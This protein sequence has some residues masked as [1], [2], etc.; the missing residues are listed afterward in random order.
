MPVWGVAIGAAA[1]CFPAGGSRSVPVADMMAISKPSLDHS[2]PASPSGFCG[3]AIPR[4]QRHRRGLAEVRSRR[5]SRRRRTLRRS[6]A[7]TSSSLAA[8]SK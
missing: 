3:C 7:A 5:G 1:T 8:A 4:V 2:Q 6:S